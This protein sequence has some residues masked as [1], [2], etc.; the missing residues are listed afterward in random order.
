V[1][2][3]DEDEEE[4]SLRCYFLDDD[5]QEEANVTTDAYATIALTI[6]V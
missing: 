1:E 2:P 6:L 4:E 5:P 3:T